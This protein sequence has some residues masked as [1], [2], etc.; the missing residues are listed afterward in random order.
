[1]NEVLR[2][3]HFYEIYRW[4]ICAGLL[5]MGVFL[6]IVGKFVNARLRESK[7]QVRDEWEDEGQQEAEPPSDPFILVNLAYWGM[8]LTIFGL[9]VIF[10]VPYEKQQ[11]LPVAAA[12]AP[13]P[14]ETKPPPVTNAPPELV[15]E[16]PAPKRPLPPNLKLQGITYKMSNASALINGRTYFIGETVSNATVVAIEGEKAVLDLDGQRMVLELPK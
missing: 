3:R 9:I 2:T 16:S 1:M 4:G 7:R 15:V 11:A 5:G 8:I 12:T 10:I 6:W 13:P 14:V